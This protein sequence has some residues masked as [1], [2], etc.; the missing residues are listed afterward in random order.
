MSL[1]PIIT[2][3]NKLEFTKRTSK[4]SIFIY[5]T[6]NNF[7]SGNDADFS[8][9]ITEIKIILHIIG[10]PDK[11]SAHV[12][13]KQWEEALNDARIGYGKVIRQFYLNN[14]V[15]PKDDPSWKAMSR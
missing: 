7:I 15:T 14:K 11:P 10:L 12:L 6:Q 5:A 13:I 4:N 2:A 8:L 1:V 3:N 9:R